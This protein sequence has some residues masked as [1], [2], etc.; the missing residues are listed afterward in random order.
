M[1]SSTTQLKVKSTIWSRGPQ[2]GFAASAATMS[3][4]P[5][6]SRFRVWRRDAQ[7]KEEDPRAR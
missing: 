1:S 2:I 7:E 6:T 3:P 5:R 4:I